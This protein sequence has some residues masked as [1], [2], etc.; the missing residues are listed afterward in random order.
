MEL[1]AEE[2]E[3]RGKEEV[4]PTAADE[5]K[6]REGRGRN[7]GKTFQE[8]VIGERREGGVKLLRCYYQR[9]VI[10]IREAGFHK[11]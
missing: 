7:P 2:E 4:E 9:F 5:G 11:P 1:T 8:K 3:R 10:W 6:G